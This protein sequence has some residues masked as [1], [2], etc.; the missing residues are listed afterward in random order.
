VGGEFEVRILGRVE[1][2]GR[3]GER[4]RDDVLDVETATS[5]GVLVDDLFV[6][7]RDNGLFDPLELLGGEPLE[8]TATIDKANPPPR[9]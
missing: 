2:L 5:L 9:A 6:Q 8:R 1:R 4:V 7:A 3:A